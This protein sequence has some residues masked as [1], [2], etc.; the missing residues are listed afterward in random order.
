M[1]RWLVPA[2]KIAV[3][4]ILALFIGRM[5]YGSWQ[6]I[7]SESW[8]LDP[9][10]LALSGVCAAAWYLVRPLGWQRLIAGFGHWVP[11]GE[12]F[13]IYRKSELSRYVPGGIWQFA[14]RVY[15]VRSH[16][17]DA[18]A[19]LAATMLDMVLAALAAMVPAAWLAGSAVP[20][21]GV[22]QKIVMFGFPVVACAIVHPPALNA[23]AAPL[24]R[25]LGQ[26]YRRLEIST[27]RMFLIW[28]AYV[29][30]WLLLAMAMA[31]FASAVLADFGR[32]HYAFVAGSYALAW[33]LAL[34]TMVAPAGVGVREGILGFLLSQALALGTAMTLAVAM[35]L[36]IIVLELVWFALGYAMPRERARS[37]ARGA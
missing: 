22:W 20:A 5:I 3:P 33:L 14:S 35:R 6:Q 36:W 18:P 7:R 25:R 16:G 4:L 24:A 21:L 23:W 17:V 8:S 12:I 31:L 1:T 11:Y 19:C 27:G 30:M 13:R 9:V 37:A 26:P 15:L 28:G 2:A 10:R 29:A 34:L 32:E